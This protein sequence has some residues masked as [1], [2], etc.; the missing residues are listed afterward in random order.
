[1]FHDILKLNRVRILQ[2]GLHHRFGRCILAANRDKLQ[3]MHTFLPHN[4]QMSAVVGLLPASLAVHTV[5]CWSD[6]T[7][8]GLPRV[9]RQ[10]LL[11]VYISGLLLLAGLLLLIILP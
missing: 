9:R 2:T 7:G 1:M 3:Q 8:I 5:V 6:G 4:A 11:A 10:D